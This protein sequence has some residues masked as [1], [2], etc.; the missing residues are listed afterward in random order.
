MY[1][2]KL[3]DFNI[4]TDLGF[5]LEELAKCGGEYVEKESCLLTLGIP[6]GKG[7]VD[8]RRNII[9]ISKE[10]LIKGK[11]LKIYLKKIFEK[12]NEISSLDEDYNLSF[13]N[14]E[15]SSTKINIFVVRT[16]KYGNCIESRKKN[17]I[18]LE[19]SGRVEEESVDRYLTRLFCYFGLHDFRKEIG[20]ED[21]I[22]FEEYEK[23]IRIVWSEM[24]ETQEYKQLISKS[25]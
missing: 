20:I 18:Y 8:G 25:E 14:G 6:K 12:M 22:S 24:L 19:I 4:I 10:D 7:I 17:N 23:I 9:Q 5:T 16:G 3:E 15:E 2:A 13:I 1:K 21:K 11:I